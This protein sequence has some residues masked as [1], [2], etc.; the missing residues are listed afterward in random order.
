MSKI[1]ILGMALSLLFLSGT[2]FSSQAGCKLSP[3]GCTPLSSFYLCGSTNM[4][5]NT[6]S[7]QKS[8]ATSQDPV[9]CNP[10]WK[11]DFSNGLWEY[12]G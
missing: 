12:M 3:D 8:P 10:K 2:F 11:V 6:M 9:K 1:L 7:Q 4:D 5:N